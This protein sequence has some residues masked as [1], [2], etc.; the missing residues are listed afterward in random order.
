MTHF[1]P[2]LC[3]T[4][5]AVAPPAVAL[6]HQADGGSYS[7]LAG[8]LSLPQL[9]NTQLQRR[10]SASLEHSPD[11]RSHGGQ[12]RAEVLVWEV[13]LHHTVQ[14]LLMV[15]M[16]HGRFLI[17]IFLIKA[18]PEPTNAASSLT[19]FL[20]LPSRSAPGF[21]PHMRPI[22][23][24]RFILEFLIIKVLQWWEVQ[25]LTVR[26]NILLFLFLI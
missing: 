6:H 19:Y 17:W 12:R 18:A 22:N 8:C 3:S 26:K 5:P 1:Y 7:A 25:F 11:L 23:N 20:S 9:P 4:A 24:I 21:S 15:Q 10:R 2:P 13:R 14:H 16:L